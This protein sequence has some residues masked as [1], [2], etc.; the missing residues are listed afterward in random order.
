MGL[1]KARTNGHEFKPS[2]QIVLDSV[3]PVFSAGRRNALAVCL[4]G[5]DPVAVARAR[6]R[7]RVDPGRPEKMAPKVKKAKKK[8][9]TKGEWMEEKKRVAMA[10]EEEKKRGVCL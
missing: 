1:V 3:I 4:V 6:E 5:R 9:K 10:M 8:K 7:W 2:L